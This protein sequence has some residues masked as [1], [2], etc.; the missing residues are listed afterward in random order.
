MAIKKRKMYKPKQVGQD[1]ISR[2]M[3]NLK[4]DMKSN[5][6]MRQQKPLTQTPRKQN[7]QQPLFAPPNSPQFHVPNYWQGE[8]QQGTRQTTLDEYGLKDEN[9]NEPYWSAEQWEEWAYDLMSSI[10][11]K[12]TPREMLPEWFVTAVDESE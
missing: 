4:K 6:T 12:L 2:G 9:A 3:S 7:Q 11:D 5:R 8:E 1:D 10:D